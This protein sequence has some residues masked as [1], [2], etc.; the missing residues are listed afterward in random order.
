[1][2]FIDAPLPVLND[3]FVPPIVRGT[4]DLADFAYQGN[5][6]DALV[7]RIR[8]SLASNPPEAEGPPGPTTPPS[9]HNSHS[10]GRRG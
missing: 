10:V 2:A 7:A 9:P 1:M 6:Y 5:G 4:A 8:R 3:S